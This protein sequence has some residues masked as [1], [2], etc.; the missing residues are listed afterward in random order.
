MS[1]DS[2]QNSIGC[3]LLGC[4]GGIA[5]GLLGGGILLVVISIILA[6]T[7]SLPAPEPTPPD[8]ADIQV[9]V[10]EEFLNRF[11]EQPPEGRVTLDIRP[12]N[13][14]QV[15]ANMP[16]DLFGSPIPIEMTSLFVLQPQ[17]QT[18]D[19]TLLDTQISGLDLQLDLSDLFN[20]DITTV[21]QDLSGAIDEIAA[22][23]GVP[24][25]ITGLTTT[26]ST[27]EISLREFPGGVN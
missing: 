1:N 19:V 6:I 2:G 5:F 9:T 18:V 8:Q 3:G 26:D 27:I 13:Q 11:L 21:N 25:I 20:E 22:T 7:T 16:V 4:L 23:L 14:I 10:D 24:V 17:G 12:G 15:R